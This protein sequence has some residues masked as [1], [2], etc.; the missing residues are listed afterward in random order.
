M[1]WQGWRTQVVLFKKLFI[2][3]NVNSWY[4]PVSAHP[5]FQNAFWRDDN[6]RIGLRTVD[7]DIPV[8]ILFLRSQAK[9]E[10]RIS[11][12]KCQKKRKHVQQGQI[13]DNIFSQFSEDWIYVTL[14]IYKEVFNQLSTTLLF[15]KSK[16]QLSD[17]FFVMS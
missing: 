6:G 5:I 3:Y 4:W 2:W 8:H 17:R 9:C 7:H 14:I 13:F 10:W 16:L 11:D 12:S 15:S 1:P